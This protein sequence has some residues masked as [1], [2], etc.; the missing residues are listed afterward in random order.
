MKTA[1]TALAIGLA[2]FGIARAETQITGAGSTFAAPIYSKWGDASSAATG[3]KLNYQAIGSGAGINQINNRTVDFGASDMPVAADQLAAHKLMQFPTVIGG[4]DIIVNLPDVKPNE[5]KLTGELLAD[6]YLGKITK[7]NDPKL[8]EMNHGIKLPNLAIAPVYR[9]DGSGTTFVYTDYLSMVSP[10]WKSKVGSSTSVKWA[11]GTGAKGSDG[12]SGTVHNIKGGIGYVES[13][14]AEM[15]HLTTTQLQ[16]KA[17]KFVTP[18]MDSYK[19]AAASAD[20][21]KVQNFAIDLN[22]QPGDNSWPIE[23]ATF[24]LLPTDPK[25][26]SQSAAVKKF[27]DWGFAHGND[28][29]VQLLYI[30]LPEAVQNAVRAVWQKEVPGTM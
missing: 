27:F 30:P 24:V 15:N 9:A 1:I 4:V 19:A 18:T 22:D 21:S 14:Y 26:P 29:A 16:N 28:I 8:V 11:A 20:W 12:V 2:G 7:W 17:G 5:L 23:S 25:D 3:I 13:A 6:I 10:D